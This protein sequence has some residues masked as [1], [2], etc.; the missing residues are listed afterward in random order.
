MICTVS[1]LRCKEIINLNSGQ[2]MGFVCDA[3]ISLPEGH[4]RA[5]II[6]GQ[7]RFFGL[8]GREEDAV[9]PWDKITKIGT[10][11][12]LVDVEGETRRHGRERGKRMRFLSY[13]F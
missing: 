2:R 9:I 5:L 12:I 8:F 4:V 7:A 6:P 1:D 10:D 11:I 13:L 3:E